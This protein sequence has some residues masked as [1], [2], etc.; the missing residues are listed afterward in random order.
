M[1]IILIYFAAVNLAGML[2]VFLDKWRAQR[3]KWRIRERTLFL[4]ALLGGTPGVYAA[5]RLC[6]HKTLHKRFMW[7]LPAIFV[8]Q[9]ALACAAAYFW[10]TRFGFPV[11]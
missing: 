11:R 6:R 1:K 5:M 4:F 3:E 2:A 7:G 9:I 8:L 10:Y